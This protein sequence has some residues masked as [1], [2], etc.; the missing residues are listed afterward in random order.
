MAQGQQQAYKKPLP[1]PENDKVTK[2]FWEA[3]KQHKLVVPRCKDCGYFH[4]YPREQC[5]HCMSKNLEW[6]EVSGKA[7]LHTFTIV[8]QPAHPAFND[9]V[10]YAH[11]VIELNEGVRMIGN[12]VGV[13]DP[14]KLQ[15]DMPLEVVFDDVTPEWTLVKW[16]PA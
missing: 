2:A 9:D 13:D 6:T 12:I 16:K 1:V 15:I 11:C 4:F 10:P 3:T 7:R 8:H 14:H 5:P